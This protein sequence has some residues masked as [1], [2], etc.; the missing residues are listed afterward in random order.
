MLLWK[1]TLSPPVRTKSLRQPLPKP[2]RVPLQI[3]KVLRSSQHDSAADVGKHGVGTYR[4]DQRRYSATI[5][6]AMLVVLLVTVILVL[7]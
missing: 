6:L 5:L 7:L 1:T 3:N 2:R 4:N